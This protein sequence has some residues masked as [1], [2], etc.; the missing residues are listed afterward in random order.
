MRLLINCVMAVGPRRIVRE[1][2][3]GR[4]PSALSVRTPNLLIRSQKFS[5]DLRGVKVSKKCPSNLFDELQKP[6]S[7][8]E[9]AV[10]FEPTIRFVHFFVHRRYFLRV[11]EDVWD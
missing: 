4:P 5:R 11:C 1:H 2:N 7:T 6:Q 8:R 3:R 9:P 10:G